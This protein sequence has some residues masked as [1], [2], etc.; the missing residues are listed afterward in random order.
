MQYIAKGLKNFFATLIIFLI[1][2]IL[3][4]VITFN[5]NDPSILNAKNHSNIGNFF[6]IYGANVSSFLIQIFGISFVFPIIFFLILSIKILCK[7]PIK[8]FILR[9]ILM[10]IGT[11]LF[12]T[13]L[14]LIIK[15]NVINNIGWGGVLGDY[16]KQIS[17]MYFEKQ[18]LVISILLIFIVNLILSLG[19]KFHEWRSI[20]KYLI[21][22]YKNIF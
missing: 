10:L 4:S 19:L 3:I 5:V 1:I 16:F 8:I 22:G 14:S 12:S 2:F 6:G 15:S 7:L 9:F 17:L 21:I 13:I 11:I 18:V 20:F